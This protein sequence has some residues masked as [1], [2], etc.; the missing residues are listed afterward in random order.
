YRLALLAARRLDAKSRWKAVEL[1]RHWSNNRRFGA[2][3]G[4][5][6]EELTAWGRR[7]GQAVPKEPAL[8]HLGTSKANESKYK[9]DD[10]LAFLERDPAGRKGD[11]ARGRQV[12]EKATCIKCHKYGKEG[13]GIGPDLT[14]VSKRFKRFDILESLVYPSKVISDQYRAQV[15]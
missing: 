13:E 11:A 3:E 9:F 14:T 15:L 8:P 7:F 12:F 2:D 1:L 10:L 5:A 4:G 6:A